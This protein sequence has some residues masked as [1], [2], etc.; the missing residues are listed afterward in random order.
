QGRQVATN[1]VEMIHKGIL[2]DRFRY[3]RPEAD[4]R[5]M[6]I[7]FRACE[8]ILIKR[9]TLSNAASWVQTYDQCKNVLIDSI[10]VDSKAYWNNDGI[11]I[12]DCD[13]VSVTNSFIDS[14]DDGICL[15]SHDPAYSCKNIVIINCTIRSS[16]NGIKFGT[17]SR[18]GFSKIKILRNTIYNTYRSAISLAA[19]DGGSIDD[20]EIDSLRA[21]HTGN[22]FF[23]R[24]GERLKGKKGRIENVHISNMYVEVPA[25]KPD[26]GYEYEGPIEDMPRNISPASIVGLPD[27]P[28]VDIT[29]T[30]IEIKYPGG[31][32]SFF[33]KASLDTPESIPEKADAYPE[34]SMFGEL[35]AWGLYIR[36]AKEIQI[37]NLVLSCG[38]KDYRIAI[39]ADDLHGASFKN[40]KVTEPEKKKIFQA[41]KSSGITGIK[42]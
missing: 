20:V 16:A 9:I 38:K 35:P 15:K 10:N 39:A 31:G 13:S 7:N 4:N 1:I 34:F 17:A 24:V 25:T 19:V 36:H 6:L 37:S 11:D 5:P 29:L 18:G 21:Y 42:P 14:S 23:L 26:A 12:V 2:K 30:N 33:A 27:V 41:N 3:D 8:N 32:N 22:A 40:V 28:I